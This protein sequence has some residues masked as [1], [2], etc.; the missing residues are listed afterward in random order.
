[1]KYSIARAVTPMAASKFE[2]LSCFKV[3]MMTRYV[4]SRVFRSLLMPIIVGTWPAAMLMAD[5][6]MNAVME[7]REIKSTIHPIRRRPIATMIHPQI[8]AKADAITCPSI[9]GLMSWALIT[10]LPTIVDMTAT[11]Y[12][13]GQ[14][15][16]TK[17]I[18]GR[19][20]TYTNSNIL[21][22]GKEPVYQ[23]AHEGRV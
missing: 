4:G 8:T 22:S 17:K 20:V 10:T 12:F 6:V 5:P 3:L 19:G 15:I 7:V 13:R 18:R 14:H 2:C 1:M 9:S 21:G 11:G 16:A 23:D